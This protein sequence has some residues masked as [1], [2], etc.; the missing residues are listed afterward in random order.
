MLSL[1]DHVFLYLYVL[2]KKTREGNAETD[3]TVS[4]VG[5]INPIALITAKTP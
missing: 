5:K 3:I 4:I 2:D 1:T